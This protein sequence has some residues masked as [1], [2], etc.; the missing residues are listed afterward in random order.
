MTSRIERFLIAMMFALLAAGI[1][2]IVASAQ[3]GNPPA[4]Q[5]ATEPPDCA[6][7][8]TEFE[9]TW[10]NG[11]SRQSWYRSLFLS[12]NGPSRASQG[13]CLVCHTTGYDPAT[14]TYKA[15]RCNLRSM[16]RPCPCR[17]S[18]DTH[19]H[20]PLPRPLW[21]LSQRYTLWLARTGK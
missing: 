1:T 15:E 6:V 4:V 7:C 18:Q 13:A 19:A 8:H 10:E 11:C 16:P 5:E 12:M 20:R 14:A 3:G 21:T 17:S 2:L 9:M